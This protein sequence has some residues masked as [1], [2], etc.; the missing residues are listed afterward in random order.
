MILF[1]SQRTDS[2][3]GVENFQVGKSFSLI[4]LVCTQYFINFTGINL[5]LLRGS[6]ELKRRSGEYAKQELLVQ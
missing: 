1:K 6:D 3:F 5:V 2:V 4:S